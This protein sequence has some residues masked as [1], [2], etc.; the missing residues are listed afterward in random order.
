[1]AEMK[2]IQISDAL[3]AQIENL[4]TATQLLT[5]SIRELRPVVRSRPKG[6]PLEL[7]H[8]LM[9]QLAIQAQFLGLKSPQDMAEIVLRAFIEMCEAETEVTLP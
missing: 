1:M 5:T 6:Q 8:E 7:P 9:R 2:T 3:T 4:T